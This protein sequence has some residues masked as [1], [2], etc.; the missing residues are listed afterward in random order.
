MNWRRGLFYAWV[1]TYRNQ[2]IGESQ[3]GY[4][5]QVFRCIIRKK[6][7]LDT[8]RLLETGEWR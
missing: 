7:P 6:A 4:W 8:T 5:V 3:V 2:R 1:V